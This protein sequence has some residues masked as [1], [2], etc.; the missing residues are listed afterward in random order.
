[1]SLSRIDDRNVWSLW[2]RGAMGGSR[3]GSGL[4]YQ[5]MRRR[6]SMAKSCVGVVLNEFRE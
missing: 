4:M 3:L 6:I 1:M 5:L 2:M